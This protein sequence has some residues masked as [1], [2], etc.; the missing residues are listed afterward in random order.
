LGTRHPWHRSAKI[1]LESAIA[2]LT[3]KDELPRAKEVA[4]IHARESVYMDPR[5]D[6][7]ICQNNPL[8]LS[9]QAGEAQASSRRG[10]ELIAAEPAKTCGDS[11]ALV[12]TISHAS[13][14]EILPTT[15]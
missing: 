1:D 6:E 12:A 13:L 4:D 8:W 15:F 14:A 3:R 11:H 10:H 2:S 5:Y 9:Y 7:E